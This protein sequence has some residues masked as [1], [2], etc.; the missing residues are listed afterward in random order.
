MTS[1]LICWEALDPDAPCVEQARLLYE[2]TLHI[3]ERIPWKWITGAVARR[4]SWR[5]GRWGTHLI[6]AGPHAKKNAP[7]R[8]LGFANA[9]HIP[10]Y[11]GYLTYVG[12]D[13]AARGQGVGTRLVEAAVRAMAFDASCEGS[14]LPFV[15]WESRPPTPGDELSAREWRAKLGLW[16]RAGGFWVAG[17]TFHAVNYMRKDAPAVPLAMFLRPVAT[18]A[19]S[20]TPDALRDVAAGLLREVYD[21]D[22]ED[23]NYLRTLPPDCVPELRPV[24]EALGLVGLPD[25]A[26]G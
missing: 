3:D 26:N 5:P 19:E 7:D 25:P 6:L 11:G 20:F 13:P 8:V 12:V 9:L 2:S 10:N 4:P 16:R 14:E 18:P 1:N 21:C 17:L 23:D 15:V 24:D 22:A